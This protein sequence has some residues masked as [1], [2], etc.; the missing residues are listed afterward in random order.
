MSRPKLIVDPEFKGLIRPLT[1][2]EREQL[3]A[4]LLADGCLDSIIV[5]DGII[6][7]GHNRY[8]ICTKHDIPFSTTEMSFDSRESAI[9]WI[10][11]HQLGRRNLSEATR[12]YLIGVQYDAE[13]LSAAHRNQMGLN[14]YGRLDPESEAEIESPSPKR[15]YT[16]ERIAKENNISPATVLKY[17]IYSR[18]VE[19]LK[20][21]V[22]EIVPKILSG[23]Y[24]IS[25]DNV[26][27]LAE[28]SPQ[29]IRKVM[30]G[31]E[32]KEEAS[33]RYKVPRSAMQEVS[34]GKE[35]EQEMRATVKDMPPYDPDAE[36]VGLTLTIPSWV[37]SL[38]RL[39]QN[40]SLDKV[41]PRAKL[42]LIKALVTLD[43]KAIK[44]TQYLGGG[45]H[46]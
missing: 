3:E 9:A 2:S 5:W 23:K 44:L 27:E 12:K 46:E 29:E 10:C 31:I 41:T 39:Q 14:Q 17:T 32:A 4:N 36:L 45:P 37:S 19:K 28:L 38:D 15:P 42:Q 22:P 34:Q 43:D 33:S 21:K 25:H 7:D 6:V 35:P 16:A 13:K 8:E 1:T 40:I 24:K 20:Q 11:A 26:I 30:R 18:A